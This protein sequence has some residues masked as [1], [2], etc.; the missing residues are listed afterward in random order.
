VAGSNNIL[1]IKLGALGDVMLCLPQ[2]A[3]ILDT[4]HADRVMLLTAPEYS[5]LFTGFPRLKVV[6]FKRKG[7]VEMLR[8]LRWLHRE[9]FDSVYDLQGSLRS[10][11]M[12]LF[13]RARLRAGISPGIAY[14]HTP[15]RGNT[16]SHAFDRFNAVLTAAGLE[17]APPE[18]CLPVT[19]EADQVVNDWLKQSRLQQKQLVLMH[20]GSSRQWLSKRWPEADFLSLAQMF[21]Q[22]GL[23]VVW[24]GG[25]DERDVNRRLAKLVGVDA[26]AAFSYSEL[27]GLGRHAVF[28]VTNDSGPMHVLAASRL[29]V[30]AFFGPTDWRASHALGQQQNVLSNPVPCSP[31]HL[32]VCPPEHQHVC[33]Q[34]ITP[35]QVLARLQKDG[36]L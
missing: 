35:G 27:A 14:S 24:T 8:V 9:R 16:P 23:T 28:A 26:T 25:E 4:H 34:D 1:V 20:A 5:Q 11:I 19:A 17:A 36:L 7:C 31:C 2:L 18:P 30:Y 12:T 32:P 3:R 29:P 13:T 33:L 6:A 15:A 22:R 21:E 10:R